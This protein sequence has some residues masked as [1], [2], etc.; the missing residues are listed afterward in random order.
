MKQCRKRASLKTKERSKA[1]ELNA[2]QW[3]Q[4]IL[5]ET[6]WKLKLFVLLILFR[7][8]LVMKEVWCC[9]SN[10]GKRFWI[11]W[12][13]GYISCWFMLIHVI[14]INRD[15]VWAIFKNQYSLFK[16][17]NNY[18]QIFQIFRTKIGEL[19][20]LET[21]HFLDYRNVFHYYHMIC[22]WLSVKLTDWQL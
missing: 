9:C 7:C 18:F 5:S 20:K 11:R 16:W 8:L 13:E 19:V 3:R 14:Q 6:I 12:V 17:I 10:H 22:K 2:E 21:I 4:I 1:F 15:L